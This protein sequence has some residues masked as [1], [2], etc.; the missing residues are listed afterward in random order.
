MKKCNGL[1]SVADV[2]QNVGFI[3]VTKNLDI[4]ELDSALTGGNDQK[5][6][7]KISIK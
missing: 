1:S 2:M 3:V 6:S 4:T 7:K 5:T